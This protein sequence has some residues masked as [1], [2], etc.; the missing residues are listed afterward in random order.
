MIY[1]TGDIHAN[2][3]DYRLEL[4]SHLKEDDIVIF[5]GDFGFNWNNTIMECFKD[6]FKFPCTVLFLSGNHENFDILNTLPT[7]EMFGGEVG[8][9]CEGVYHLKTGEVYTI[10][11]KKFLVFGGALSIDKE[12]RILGTS[13]W[14]EEIPSSQTYCKTLDCPGTEITHYHRHHQRRQIAIQHR[15]IRLLEAIGDHIGC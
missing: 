13:Y 12:H 5:L 14:E 11:N 3:R 9:F 15:R 8:I 10:G 6:H 2:F 4:M 7:K 1:L